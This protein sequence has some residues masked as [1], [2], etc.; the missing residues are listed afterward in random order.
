MH[1]NVVE[2]LRAGRIPRTFFYFID[3]ERCDFN[4]EA[5]ISGNW[6]PKVPQRDVSVGISE[7]LKVMMDIAG[8]ISFIHSH[9]EIHRD[10][11]P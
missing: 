3:M 7:P 5:Y 2:V 9:K 11:K 10:L 1:K 8:G 4:L 6:V